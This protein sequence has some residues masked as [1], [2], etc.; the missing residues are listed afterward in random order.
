LKAID[1]LHPSMSER[2]PDEM[3]WNPGMVAAMAAK[4]TAES[5]D[6]ATLHLGYGSL[7]CRRP[8]SQAP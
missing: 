7:A 1:P 8:V 2:S 6:C 4:P 5:P 3:K